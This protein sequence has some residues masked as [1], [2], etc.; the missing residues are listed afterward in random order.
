V[1]EDI[2]I[3]N[4]RMEN[5]LQNAIDFEM[6]YENGGAGSLEGTNL[7]PVNEGTPIFRNIHFEN[8]ICLGAQKAMVLD[9]LP[10]MPIKDFDLKNVSIIAKQGAFVTDADGIT[11]ENVHVEAQSGPPLTETRVTNSRLDLAQ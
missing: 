1:V 4:V 2:N 3:H 5:I 10:E 8:I 9:G 6:F 11:F 7:P